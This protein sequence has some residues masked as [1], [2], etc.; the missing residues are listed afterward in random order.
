[1]CDAVEHVC[2]WTSA[3]SPSATWSVREP[4][5]RNEPP[6]ILRTLADFM[7]VITSS[8]SKVTS[9][10]HE[11]VSDGCTQSFVMKSLFMISPF[12]LICKKHHYAKQACEV[13]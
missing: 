4:S 5:R 7:E 3:V 10:N 8:F 6:G 13:N 11:L 12:Y 2:E 1:M 9:M